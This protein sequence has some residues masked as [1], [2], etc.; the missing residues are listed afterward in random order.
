ML[1]RSAQIQ[2]QGNVLG[3]GATALKTIHTKKQCVPSLT[4]MPFNM[5]SNEESR[6]NIIQSEPK[7]CIYFLH[8]I[9]PCFVPLTHWVLQTV[10]EELKN[11]QYVNCPVR[12]GGN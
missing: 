3:T 9:L 4:G 7:I 10:Q 11:N 1:M 8:E 5:K 12:S 6:V 2:V